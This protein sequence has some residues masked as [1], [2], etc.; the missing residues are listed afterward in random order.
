MISV[1][2]RAR[3]G[4]HPRSASA[5]RE[6]PSRP[7]FRR[8]SS[9]STRTTTSSASS[10]NPGPGTSAMCFSTTFR[11]APN[12]TARCAG[13]MSPPSPA[14]SPGCSRATTSAPRQRCG[15]ALRHWDSCGCR[16][17]SADAEPHHRCAHAGQCTGASVV[18]VVG[19]QPRFGRP[20]HRLLDLPA[21]RRPA[22]AR[23]ARAGL[24]C[25]IGRFPASLFLSARIFETT[26][27]IAKDDAGTTR[28]PKF[29]LT[30]DAD[31]WKKTAVRDER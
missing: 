7:L 2:R 16:S 21:P 30:R 31:F 25:R 20:N 23:R 19:T 14:T 12:A 5:L 27:A 13:A 15:L 4:T 26:L 8:A 17:A 6:S 9:T 18:W 3:I 11:S 24:P 22:S 28:P 10:A 29:F 1:I